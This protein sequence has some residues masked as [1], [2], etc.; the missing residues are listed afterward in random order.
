ML[1][2]FRRFAGRPGPDPERLIR[3]FVE[4]LAALALK[5]PRRAG[6]ARAVTLAPARSPDP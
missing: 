2:L 1:S 3:R 4:T 5:P 6:R